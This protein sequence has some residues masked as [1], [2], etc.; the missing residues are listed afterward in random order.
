MSSRWKLIDQPI[1]KDGILRA[2]A[3]G[4]AEAYIPTPFKVNHAPCLT[5]LNNGDLLAVWFAGYTEEG[6]RDI[7][8]VMSRL[9]AGEER[10]SEPVKVSDDD[11]RSEQNPVLFQTAEGKL[12]LLYTAQ[13]THEMSR[14]EFKRL[15]PGKTFTRQETSVIRCR[16][17]EDNGE[18]WTPSETWF[19]NPGSFCRAPIFPLTDGSWLFPMWYS[20]SDGQTEYGSD[21]SVVQHSCDQGATWREY[22]VPGSRG[23]VHA[24]IVGQEGDKLLAFFRSRA[25]DRI[26]ISRS[27]DAGRTWSEP[28]RTPLPNNNASI[29]AIRLQSGAIAVIYNHASGGDDPQ[30]TVWPMTRYPVTI[31]ISEDEGATWPFRRHLETGDN[32]CGEANERLNSRYEYPW[33]TQSRDGLIH[34]AFAYGRRQGIKHLIVSENWVK[35]T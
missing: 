31:A 21:Y 22:P 32:Y 15:H 3:W 2:C 10:W 6:R 9:L 26:Y 24:S 13:E 35:G 18:T 17:S 11:T 28:E 5:E 1:G 34:A 25:A 16:T 14:E 27:P 7:H 23:R 4:G 29:R 19:N 20:V 12:L 30:A 8:I 33:I